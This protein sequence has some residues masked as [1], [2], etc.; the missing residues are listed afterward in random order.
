MT[1]L[2]AWIGIVPLKLCCQIF[3]QCCCNTTLL[4]KHPHTCSHAKLFLNAII[5]SNTL[6]SSGLSWIWPH[7]SASL[8]VVYINYRTCYNVNMFNFRKYTFV[9]YMHFKWWFNALIYSSSLNQYFIIW[10][11]EIVLQDHKQ[12][13]SCWCIPEYS[14]SEA[15]VLRV[16]NRLSIDKE[17]CRTY[18]LISESQTEMYH[19]H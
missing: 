8:L 2:L 14:F 1:Y 9:S 19:F 17:L 11:E 18:L 3:M 7:L 6:T 13:H 10:K 4:R 5:I 15:T 16:E 12:S